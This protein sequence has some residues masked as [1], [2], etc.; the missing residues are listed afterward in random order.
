[1]S[2]VKNISVVN[3]EVLDTETSINEFCYFDKPWYRYR[4]LQKLCLHIFVTTLAST[5]N[6][7]DGSMLNGLQVFER[8]NKAMSYPSGAVLGALSNGTT[9]GAILAY[10][11]ASWLSDKIGRKNATIAGST[12]T[13][14][15]SILQANSTNYAFF[16]ITRI[17]LGFGN[18]ITAVSC[19]LLI[20]EI[21]FPDMKKESEPNTTSLKY[22]LSAF[23]STATTSYGVFWYLG[24]LVAAWVTYGTRVMHTSYCWRIPSYM[25][26]FFPIV[27]IIGTWFSPESPR[28]LISKGRTEE[29]RKVI[30]YYHT[31][32]SDDERSRRFVE[33]QIKEIQASIE[34]D[35]ASNLSSYVDFIKIP[36]F[37]KRLFL[38]VIVGIMVNLSG[39]GLVSYYLNLVLDSIGIKSEDMKL[40]INGYLMTYNFVISLV[41]AFTVGRFRRRTIFLLSTALMLIFYVIWTILSALNQKSN[42]EHKSLSNGVLAMIFLYYFGYNL[43]LNGL[44]SL[45]ITELLPYSH[46]AKGV[47]I[48]QFFVNALII[49][50]GFVNPVAMKA[51]EWK[52]YIVYC[53]VLAVE[54]IVVYFTF[55]E[56]SGYTLEEASEIFNET[57]RSES[58][59][60]SDVKEVHAEVIL[61]KV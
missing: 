55:V 41:I 61:S 46:R 30:K 5:N 20:A 42:F 25:Q 2:S 58:I 14:I 52:Y 28:Y 22:K 38:I 3:V 31:G 15:G 51:I 24:A 19:P 36:S 32:D 59:A 12:I 53:C 48:F 37:R 57:A 54:F 13:F 34:L 18:G 35:K 40:Q 33:F 49:F 56:T 44:C 26:G 29:A 47:N 7:Y 16:L 17:I 45:Y 27:Q 1:M 39:N 10:F 50:N 9:F 60:S 8:W 6:G 23:R 43:A 21:S 11:V 4:H